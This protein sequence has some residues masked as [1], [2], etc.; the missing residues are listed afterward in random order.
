MGGVVEG[1]GGLGEGSV[2]VALFH[3]K[4]DYPCFYDCLL[5]THLLV[6]L[7]DRGYQ[8]FLPTNMI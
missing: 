8:S 2:F 5:K 3:T 7:L 4:L 1:G 6:L